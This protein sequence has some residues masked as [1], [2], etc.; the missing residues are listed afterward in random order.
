MEN[1]TRHI[2]LQLEIL[3]KEYPEAGF[4]IQSQIKNM[5]RDLLNSEDS[6]QLLQQES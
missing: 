3:L 1:S 6:L 2:M 4:Y 5:I